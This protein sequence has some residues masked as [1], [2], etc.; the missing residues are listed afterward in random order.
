[1]KSV[2]R[3]LGRRKQPFV[4]YKEFICGRISTEKAKRSGRPIEMSTTEKIQK[5]HRMVINDS[6]L[7]LSKIVE[8]MSISKKRVGNILHD[9]FHM[10]K[11]CAK[12]VPHFLTPDQKQNRLIDS[13]R[14][15]EVFKRNPS[16]FL[17]LFMT[18]DG[19]EILYYTL[20]SDIHSTEC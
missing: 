9:H 10:R 8:T 2:I 16:K 11:L 1:M 5:I 14:C 19:T 7:K 12:W 13:A 18:M 15:L 4:R 3:N 17:L 6:K 20:E